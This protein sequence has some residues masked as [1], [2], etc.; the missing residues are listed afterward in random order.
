MASLL[1]GIWGLPGVPTSTDLVYRSV[2]SWA[3]LKQDFLEKKKKKVVPMAE[4][5]GVSCEALS[6]QS[7]ALTS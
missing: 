4:G 3:L 5:S 7:L 2:A 6:C 1:V